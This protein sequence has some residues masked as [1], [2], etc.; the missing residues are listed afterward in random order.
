[1][2]YVQYAW[3][4]FRYISSK[5]YI[6]IPISA[7]QVLKFNI[8]T[9]IIS[10]VILSIVLFFFLKLFGIGTDI[11]YNGVRESINDNIKEKR[12]LKK[13]KKLQNTKRRRVQGKQIYNR[14]RTQGIVENS[15]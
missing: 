7:T 1:M 10:L 6:P 5:I 8:I 2:V 13:A 11:L 15:K 9:I 3:D 4:S 14:R 12:E